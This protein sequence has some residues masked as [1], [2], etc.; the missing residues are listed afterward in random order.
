MRMLE[1]TPWH[2]LPAVRQFVKYGL[3][4]ASNTIVNF[5]VYSVGV[6]IGIDYLVALVLGY[7]V[8]SFNSYV[9]NRHWTF[10][11]GDVAHATAGSRFALVQVCAI[12]ANLGLLYLLVHHAGIAKI[13]AQAI[14]VLPILAVTF[15]IN[16]WWSFAHPVGGGEPPTPAT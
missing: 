7:T 9:L 3:V 4:G 12:A 13:P 5:A 15:P 8:G 16:R 11:A 1:A 14:L 2:E 10:R 6:T